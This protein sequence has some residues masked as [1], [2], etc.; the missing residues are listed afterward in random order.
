[1]VWIMGRDTF[2]ALP[3]ITLSIGNEKAC[4]DVLDTMVAKLKGG[5]FP[6]MG[7]DDNPALI[8]LMPALVFLVGAAICPCLKHTH[9]YGL[10]MAMP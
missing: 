7:A 10:P 4:K 9:R 2:I 8:R 5:L 1:M 6:N 3:G